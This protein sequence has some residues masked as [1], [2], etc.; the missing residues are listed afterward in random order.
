R[1]SPRR[2]STSM[3]WRLSSRTRVPSPSSP[4]GTSS[5]SRSRPRA[6]PCARRAELTGVA[7]PR[8]PAG[9]FHLLSRISSMT[10]VALRKR[11]AWT[12]LEA[13]YGKIK[14]QTLHQ[15]FAEDAKRGERLTVEAVGMFL[16]YSKNRVTD[17][18]L[19]LLLQLA[20]QSEL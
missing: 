6:R 19:K 2:G 20:D 18:T 7:A 12:A 5:W 4:R 13:H 10:V 16:D 8:H 3:P 15:L 11:P 9:R 17:E 14:D 1:S